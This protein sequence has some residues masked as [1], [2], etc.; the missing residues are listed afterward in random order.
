MIHT[1]APEDLDAAHDSLATIEIVARKPGRRLLLFTGDAML[2]RRYF[3]PRDGEARLVRGGEVLEDGKAVLA[4]IKPYMELA[5]LASV[6]ME[7]QLSEAKLT[8]IASALM[9]GERV[10]LPFDQ[11]LGY[12]D[13]FEG[14]TEAAG[15]EPQEGEGEKEDDH[16][17]R[18]SP[19]FP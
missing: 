15:R 1:F 12:M 16:H 8:R 18:P 14:R 7:T 4:T 9:R 13:S 11:V 19:S 6:N 5:D 3:E 17:N 10:E 2:A